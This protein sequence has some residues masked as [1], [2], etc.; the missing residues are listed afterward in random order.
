M[1]NLL[2]SSSLDIYCGSNEFDL[3]NCD[4]YSELVG[5]ALRSVGLLWIER[6]RER[7]ELTLVKRSMSEC[8][9]L[10]LSISAW[11]KAAICSWLLS[12]SYALA[13]EF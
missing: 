4:A 3:T 5:T 2:A 12:L 10:V 8:L 11:T 13:R 9:E 1:L 7:S 6:G